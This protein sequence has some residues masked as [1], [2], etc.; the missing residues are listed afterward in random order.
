MHL[1]QHSTARRII[2][3]TL[4]LSAMVVA[5]ASDRAVTVRERDPITDRTLS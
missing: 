4:L 1:V 2:R 5:T 3:E